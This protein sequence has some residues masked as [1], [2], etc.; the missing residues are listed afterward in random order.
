VRGRKEPGSQTTKEVKRGTS[1][2]KKK[3]GQRSCVERKRKER[4]KFLGVRL[5]GKDGE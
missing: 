2:G 1:G 5:T 4:K 3:K